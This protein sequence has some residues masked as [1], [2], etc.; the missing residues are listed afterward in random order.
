MAIRLAP[1][2]SKIGEKCGLRV[3][4]EITSHFL[5]ADMPQI[6][7]ARLSEIRG[8]AR[9]TLKISRLSAGRRCGIDAP[10]KCE[11]ISV[12]T[13]RVRSVALFFDRILSRRLICPQKM[14]SYCCAN[15]KDKSEALSQVIGWGFSNHAS[16]DFVEVMNT[17]SLLRA[18]SMNSS[19]PC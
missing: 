5:W 9:P 12:R 1:L 7:S 19:N 15:P 2:A 4:A 8:V 18:Y 11:V 16:T 14:R 10:R 3:R 17:S 6:W 13:L